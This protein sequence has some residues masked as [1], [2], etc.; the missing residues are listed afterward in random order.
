MPPAP[1]VP[2]IVRRLL[3][4]LLL[5]TATLAQDVYVPPVPIGIKRGGKVRTAKNPIPFPDG[6]KSWVRLRSAHYDVLSNASE[7]Q[8]RAIV[9]GLETLA[10]A[11]TKA[12]TRF[13]S[14]AVPT[15]VLIF[16]DRAE[17]LPYFEL[18]VGV[19]KPAVTGLY[20][21]HG[22]G[23]TMFIDAS[24]RQQRIGKTSLHELV[25]DLL[26]QGEHNAPHW[27]DEGL[28]EYFAN[29]DIHD[30]KF[31]AGLPIDTHLRYVRTGPPMPLEKMFAVE[32]ETN[33]SLSP[34]FY[35]QSWA[36]VDWLLRIDR[37]R[38]F[39]F[40]EEVEGGAS[41][42]DALRKHYGKELR[43]MELGIRKTN[44]ASPRIELPASNVE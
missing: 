9:S 25:H 22:G 20:V 44:T 17:I 30:G 43:D 15:T 18:L 41:I 1:V 32:P 3:P 29:G 39:P 42:A 19:E 40:L 11:L 31:V 37:D 36:A 13:R 28:A 34:A 5:A 33:E 14:A 21:R 26:H 24:R 12:S 7:E 23:G 27:I 8:T 38:F 35:A 4:I 2:G 16:T 10:S 6:R